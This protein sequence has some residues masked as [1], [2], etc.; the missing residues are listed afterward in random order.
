MKV[1]LTNDDGINAP[2]LLVVAKW[3]AKRFDQV[4]LAAPTNQQSGKSHAINIHQPIHIQRVPYPV[5]DIVAYSVDSTPVDCVR[6]ATIG[7]RQ[8]FDLIISG[9]NRGYNIGEDILYSG[10]CGAIFEAAL[11]GI[12]GVA[13]ST[14]YTTFDTAEAELDNIFDYIFDNQL[15]ALNSIYNVNIPDNT[16]KGILVTKMGGPYYSDEFIAADEHT[17][18]QEG[19]MVYE[20]GSD[21]TVDTDATMNGYTTITP[22]SVK[23][24]N[25]DVAE[26]LWERLK[27]DK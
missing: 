27:L 8:S 15:F 18:H 6:Y 17:F 16:P 11:R 3:A 4:V 23:R 25:P 13:L 21:F 10:T 5:D 14:H 7:L 1:L 20:F 12:C 19:Y 26:L 22:L 2:G 24:D 9:I